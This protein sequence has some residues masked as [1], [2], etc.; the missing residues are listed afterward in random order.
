MFTSRTTH[1]NPL[2]ALQQVVVVHGFPIIHRDQPWFI[3]A[4]SPSTIAVNH[5]EFTAVQQPTPAVDREMWSCATGMSPATLRTSDGSSPAFLLR[6]LV[7]L[8]D[9][10]M[11]KIHLRTARKICPR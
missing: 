11:T 2:H 3:I 6:R 5:Y 8:L 7:V 4:N 9:Q 1:D 10:E